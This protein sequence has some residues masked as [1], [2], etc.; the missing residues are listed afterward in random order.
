MEYFSGNLIQSIT[1]YFIF[2]T[3]LHTIVQKQ[4]M[5]TCWY[6][7]IIKYMDDGIWL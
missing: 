7:H 5:Y 6:T 1:I 4:C 2:F 3:I